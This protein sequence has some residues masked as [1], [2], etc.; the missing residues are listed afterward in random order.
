MI[1]APFH[2]GGA[3]RRRDHDATRAVGGERAVGVQGQERGDLRAPAARH[4]DDA[5]NLMQRDDAW[6][7]GG[8]AARLRLAGVD[9]GAGDA[10]A[11]AGG[12]NE[13]E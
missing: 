12:E 8:N 4:R 11:Q 2:R 9:V 3:V 10:A 7:R 13:R 6:R 1:A 5:R